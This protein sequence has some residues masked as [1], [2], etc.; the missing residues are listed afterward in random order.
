MNNLLPVLLS[1]PPHPLSLNPISD[2]QF[3]EGIKTQI[4]NVRKIPS[5]TLLQD[6]S[7]GENILNVRTTVSSTR[8]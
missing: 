2:Q 8:I 6:T 1:F 4:E 3:D 7:S 5:R